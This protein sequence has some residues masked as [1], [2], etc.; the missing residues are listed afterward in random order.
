MSSKLP[1]ELLRDVVKQYS[2][3][4]E[5]VHSIEKL[6]SNPEAARTHALTAKLIKGME[7]AKALDQ[8]LL[9]G[10]VETNKAQE[11]LLQEKQRLMKAIHD[12]ITTLEPRLQ[13]VRALQK[14]EIDKI[15]QGRKTA[16]RYGRQSI[17][18]K[19]GII[20]SSN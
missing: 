4:L 10:K 2:A 17:K 16:S 19:G 11:S 13:S 6:L 12:K 1:D 5:V 15:V 20:N 7:Q 18:K 14:D 8:K 9:Q 3:V